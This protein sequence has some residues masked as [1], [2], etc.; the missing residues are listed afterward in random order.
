MIYLLYLLHW[1]KVPS[2]VLVVVFVVVVGHVEGMAPDLELVEVGMPV[3]LH[4][5]RYYGG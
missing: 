5:V 4:L 2:P 3:Q 1:N